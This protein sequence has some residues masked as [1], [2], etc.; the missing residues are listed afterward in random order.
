M[1][2]TSIAILSFAILFIVS[3]SRNDASYTVEDRI[4][5]TY[6]FSD[7]NP[8]PILTKDKRLYPY[9]AFMGYSSESE[10]QS[11]QVIKMENDYIEVFML[12]EVGGKVWGAVDKSNG[13]EFIY[14]NEVMKFRNIALRGPW[15]SG[16]IEFNFGII[17]HTP[18]TATKVD[19]LVRKN[20]DGSISTFVG[21]MDLP[22]RTFWRVEVN[23]EK[24]RSNFKTNTSWYNSTS[25]VQPYYNWMTGAAFAKDDLELVFP[26]NQ[27]LKHNGEVR[28]WPIDDKGRNLSLYTNN[29]FG[30]HKSY[31]VI[32]YWKNFFGGYYHNDGYGFGHWANHDE[33]PGQKLWLWSLSDQG[34]IWEDHLTDTDG[35]YIEFQAGRQFVQYREDQA[36]N[37]PVRKASFDPYASDQW[38]EYWFPVQAIGGIS[39][40]SENG[41]LNIQSVPDSGNISIKLHSFISIDGVVNVLSNSKLIASKEISFKPMEIHTLLV[42]SISIDGMEVIVDELNLHFNTKLQT[43]LLDRPFKLDKKAISAMSKYDQEYFQGYELLKERFYQ[44]ARDIFEKV[45]SKEPYHLQTR[46]AMADLYYRSGQYE[47]GLEMINPSLQLNTYDPESNFIAGNLYRALGNHINA[48]ESYGWSARSMSHRSAA[49]LEMAEIYL[50]EKQYDLA[51]E[52]AQKSLQFNQLNMSARQVLTMAYRMKDDPVKARREIASLLSIDPLH[53]I[54][55]LESYFLNPTDR[56][57]NHYLSL[58]NNEYQGQTHLE[59]V[60]SYYNRGFNNDAKNLFVRLN[61]SITLDPISQIWLAYITQDSQMLKNIK[62]ISADYAHPFRRETIQALEWA[63]NNTPEWKL[64][65]Y[66]GLNYWAKDRNEEAIAL[67]NSLENTPDSMPFYISRAKLND[68]YG[69]KDQTE[70]DLERAISYAQDSWIAYLYAVQYYQENKMWKKAESFSE[71]AYLKFSDNFNVH[72]LHAKSLLYLGKVDE[73]INILNNTKVLPSEMGKESRQLYEWALLEKSIRLIRSKQL[74]EA[75]KIIKK[76][77][78]WPKNLGIG[79]PYETD[80]RIQDVLVDYINNPL[81]S[82]KYQRYLDSIAKT[83]DSYTLTLIRS[84]KSMMRSLN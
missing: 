29:Q 58:I 47:K 34:G 32:G 1:N 51:I 67:F 37:N 31:H 79:K 9:H 71:K 76:S 41:V 55:N 22:S 61:N 50:Y 15:T 18:A 20:N 16:G 5:S 77:R 84:A 3:C 64:R 70:K 26:G 53:H 12:P 59:N 45:L 2:K 17:G 74:T 60:I 56:N 6:P 81:S 42:D 57:W 39:E 40:A 28:K 46:T 62:D 63:V 27:Y 14:R 54:A 82:A 11:W 80:E 36:N 75:R 23:L 44:E 73:C 43:K 78:E 48:K 35:Q 13:E 72:V 49:F 4:I 10:P 65:Y 21:G 68:T 69:K 8:I 38:T 24:D 33:M 25:M 30:G 52:Y 19:Y 7:P 83:S 66:L